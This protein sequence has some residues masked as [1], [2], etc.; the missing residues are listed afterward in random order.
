MGRVT[1]VLRDD[2]CG[3]LP[4]REDFGDGRRESPCWFDVLKLASYEMTDGRAIRSQGGQNRS[5]DEYSFPLVVLKAQ[6]LISRTG[7]LR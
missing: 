3:T 6:W 7:N 4:G 5:H 1:I 2:C